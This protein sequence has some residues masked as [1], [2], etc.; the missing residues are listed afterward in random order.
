MKQY[1]S[2]CV[3][4]EKQ[5]NSYRAWK[6][7]HKSIKDIEKFLTRTKIND[8]FNTDEFHNTLKSHKI[9]ILN[10][11]DKSVRT[12]TV[13]RKVLNNLVDNI[14]AHGSDCQEDITNTII[15]CLKRLNIKNK[16]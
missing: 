7:F 15:C 6:S 12:N 13:Q 14:S 16:Y 2:R 1:K 11:W 4:Y 8:N 5:V 3:Q 9:S 10:S